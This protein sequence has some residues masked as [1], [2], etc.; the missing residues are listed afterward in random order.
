MTKDVTKDEWVKAAV[1]LGL[2]PTK[3]AARAVPVAKLREEVEAHDAA[4]EDAAN[5]RDEEIQQTAQPAPLQLDYA[6]TW[7]EIEEAKAAGDSRH[8]PQP[9]TTQDR[10][11]VKVPTVLLRALHEARSLPSR[12][13]HERRVRE[14][15]LRLV[16]R[17]VQRAAS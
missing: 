1:A 13:R 3:T 15:R 17:A 5:A 2:Y 16:H 6:E 12:N 14:A 11:E 7:W 4:A 8:A 10:R 9:T